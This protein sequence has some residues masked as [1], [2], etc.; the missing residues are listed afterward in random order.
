[1]RIL[2]SQPS[3]GAIAARGG[4]LPESEKKPDIDRSEAARLAAQRS[5]DDFKRSIVA[6]AKA[7]GIRNLDRPSLEMVDKRRTQLW[8]AMTAVL[9]TTSV[10]LVT[11]S[12]FASAADRRDLVDATAPWLK[13]V[14]IGCSAVFCLY[15][16]DRELALRRLERSLIDE[17]VM[18]AALSN[19]LKELSALADAGK[20]INSILELDDVLGIILSAALG[21]LGG[22]EGSIMLMDEDSEHLELYTFRGSTDRYK[23]DTR[24][25][26]DQGIAGHVVQ[27]REPLVIAGTPDPGD[28]PGWIEKKVSIHSAMCVPLI[29]RG[30]VLGVLNI[31]DTVG[32]RDFNDYDVRT[33]KLFAD[34][35]SVAISNARMFEMEKD[36]VNRL[37][38]VDRMKSEFVATVSHE[39]R[40]PLTSVLGAAATLK[41]NRRLDE[42]ARDEFLNMIERQGNRLVRLVEDILFASKIEAGE[43]P[44]QIEEVNVG[45]VVAEAATD[46]QARPGGDRI[47]IALPESPL[48]AYADIGAVQQVLLNLV[49]NAFKY[50]GSSGK[51]TVKGCDAGDIIEIG[52]SDEGPGIA[53]EDQEFI[54][55]RFRQADSS[56]KRKSV[57]VGLGL[58]IVRNL[59]E[60]QG[61]H[62]RLVSDIG[63]GAE[64]IF[65]LP[66]Q[67]AE[68]ADDLGGPGNVAKDQRKG[69][70]PARAGALNR[71]EAGV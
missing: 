70:G 3:A 38:E 6:Q 49:E 69:N 43:S 39:L 64:F 59:V 23:P 50:G 51:I 68:T 31:N 28:F 65:S 27:N 55:E 29:S 22:S 25:P 62:L 42:A 61:G 11:V 34:H 24:V 18:T 1:M 54:F 35:A 7:A 63:E 45:A 4:T 20:A 56:I 60:G 10:T 57:G 47:V 67:P 52:V 66:K 40:T 26:A 58:Y 36:H 15:V 2:Q 12:L 5:Q 71:E 33:L 16:I 13:W 17:R 8:I 14:L 19:R 37:V 9:L 44:L 30:E 41:R 53:P 46:L 48:I 21:L 32:G